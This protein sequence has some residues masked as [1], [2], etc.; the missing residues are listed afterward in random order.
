MSEEQ[1]TDYFR[2]QA[3]EASEPVPG[4]PSRRQRRRR[5]KLLIRLSVAAAVSMVLLAVAVFGGGYLVVNHLASSIHRIHGIAALDA[6]NQPRAYGGGMTVLLTGSA[7][8]PASVGGNGIDGSSTAG[9]MASGLI[10]LV[11]LNASQ[12]A[13]SVVSI[14]ANAVVYVPGYG[15]RELWDALTL[16]GPS[17]LIETVERLTDVRI[18]HYS[19]LD[20][21]GVSRVIDALGGV[22]VDVPYTTVSMGFTFPAG[23]NYLDGANVLP[24][25]R[26][27]AVSEIGREF[28]QQNLIRAILDKLAIRHLL[29][30]FSTD[31]SVLDALASVLSVDSN[32]T[33]SG[34]ESLALQLGSL[35]GRDG[36]FVHA[37]TVGGSSYFGGTLPVQLDRRLSQ[38]LWSAIRND[39]VAAFARRYP[40]TVT[41]IDPG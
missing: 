7:M 37:P 5:R 30:H 14:P 31:Y 24:Y 12:R 27:P 19:V 8:E 41:P 11:H 15:R 1:L 3:D 32:F 26:Q 22:T 38:Q 40:F 6:K 10:A 9:E 18:N 13:G 17:L 21:D 4:Q 39:S 16:G 33:N 29:S 35:K 23:Q 34:L 2:R 20:F 25:V 36:T 28:L